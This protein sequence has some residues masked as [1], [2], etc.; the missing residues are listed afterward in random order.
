[1]LEEWKEVCMNSFVA[2]A[3]Q[4]ARAQERLWRYTAARNRR[5]RERE[6]ERYLKNG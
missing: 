2:N 5:V 1:M 4:S 3:N 6:L